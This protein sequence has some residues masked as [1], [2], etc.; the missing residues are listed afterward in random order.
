MQRENEKKNRAE[1]NDTNNNK[2]GKISPTRRTI[3]LIPGTLHTD[4][5]CKIAD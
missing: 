2:L 4:L 3:C 1:L 5:E